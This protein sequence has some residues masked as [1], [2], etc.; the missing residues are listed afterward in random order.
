MLEKKLGDVVTFTDDVIKG[1][2]PIIPEE[3]DWSIIERINDSKEGHMTDYTSMDEII[4]EI[5]DNK[6]F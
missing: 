2:K 1:F 4:N 5:L 3:E 6:T